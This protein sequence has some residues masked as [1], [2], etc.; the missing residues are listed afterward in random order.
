MYGGLPP[1]Q[2]AVFFLECT[3][4][5]RLLWCGLT[6]IQEGGKSRSSDGSSG[7]GRADG[8]GKLEGKSS[9]E[10]AGIATLRKA[11]IHAASTVRF[12]PNLSKKMKWFFV[13]SPV[14]RLM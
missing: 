6:R 13:N 14:E 11:T 9:K 7:G 2:S 1:G 12:P 8:E 10:P 3:F 5:F 4:F